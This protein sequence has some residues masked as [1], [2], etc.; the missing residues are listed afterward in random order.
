MA[1][2][3]YWLWL[4]RLWPRRTRIARTP[5][6][7]PLRVG[8]EPLG[9]RTLLSGFARFAEIGPSIEF[10]RNY[11]FRAYELEPTVQASIEPT[12]VLVDEISSA[13][14]IALAKRTDGAVPDAYD[15]VRADRNDTGAATGGETISF[16]AI[17]PAAPMPINWQ[18]PIPDGPSARSGR[19]DRAQLFVNF[20]QGPDGDQIGEPNM[21]GPAGNQRGPDTGERASF[22]QGMYASMLRPTETD[23]IDRRDGSTPGSEA[24]DDE[25]PR[26]DAGGTEFPSIDRIENPVLSRPLSSIFRD[27]RTDTEVEE[28]TPAGRVPDLLVS[29]DPDLSVPQAELLPLEDGGRALVAALVAGSGNDSEGA[30]AAATSTEGT[31]AG[32]PVGI[33]SGPPVAEWSADAPVTTAPAEA[34]P[35]TTRASHVTDN[36]PGP[37][38]SDSALELPLEDTWAG[39]GESARPN[40]KWLDALFAAGAVLF[41]YRVERPVAKIRRGRESL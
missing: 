37:V 41:Q 22:E 7:A 33:D 26:A 30:H 32:S 16:P 21:P 35:V 14:P 29:Y 36:G 8:I 1:G 17:T 3:A 31:P 39:V 28:E 19:D 10:V 38:S 18:I 20:P 13:E 6:R 23:R 12:V 25:T 11:S 15:S 40:V 4:V 27:Q 24:S 2:L 9:D 34:P 5:S